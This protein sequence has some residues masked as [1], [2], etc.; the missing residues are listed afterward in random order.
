MHDLPPLARRNT[1]A[2]RLEQGQTVV[3]SALAAEFGTSE[4]VIRRDL[5]SLAAE[6]LCRR[7]YGGALPLSARGRPMSER[8]PEGQVRKRA[9]AR[10]A[11]ELI[12]PGEY[13]FLDSG[14][15]NLELARLLPED[16]EL[17][18]ATNSLDIAALLLR[19]LDVQLIFVGGLVHPLVGGCVDAAAC[20]AVAQMNIDRCFVGVCAIGTDTGISAF[21]SGDATFKRT[22]VAASRERVALIT[23]EK[24]EAR[25]PHRISPIAGV[26]TYIV[27]NDLAATRLAQLRDAGVSVLVAED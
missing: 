11:A 14:S 1:I 7:V 16:H 4:D 17:T 19:R 20:A 27:D 26:Q 8:V 10:R 12:Q 24:F 21:D 15:A 3:A 13:V 9:L 18:V 2:E 23:T 25:A 22:L 6:G 5:R